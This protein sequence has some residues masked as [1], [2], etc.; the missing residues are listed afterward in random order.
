MMQRPLSGSLQE[1]VQQ[2]WESV[3]RHHELARLLS[4]IE[5]LPRACPFLRVGAT[6]RRK[7]PV[8]FRK[9]NL[10]LPKMKWMFDTV[11]KQ[12]SGER[13]HSGVREW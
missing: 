8:G 7:S 3:L 9:G 12:V 13:A 10:I 4:N 6:D 11:R 2:A 1:E 5:K